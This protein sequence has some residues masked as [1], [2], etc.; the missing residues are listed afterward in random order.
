MPQ[1]SRGEYVGDGLVAAVHCGVHVGVTFG[2]ERGVDGD[3]EPPDALPAF[4]ERCDAA[5]NA[6]GSFFCLLHGDLVMEG[7]GFGGLFQVC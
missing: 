4:G 6:H 5:G 3:G 7:S 2:G 1:L